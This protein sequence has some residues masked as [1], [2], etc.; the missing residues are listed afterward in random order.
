MFEKSEDFLKKDISV[1]YLSNQFDTNP[2]YLSQVIQKHKGLNFN[3]YIN[4]LRINYI[5]DLLKNNPEYR[6]YKISYLAAITGFSSHSKF[7]SIFKKIK[8][9]SPS[10]FVNKLEKEE[11]K[12]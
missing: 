10:E 5:A 6:Q 2:K 12:L 3:N 7:A 9:V 11:A 1:S 4:E 8:R